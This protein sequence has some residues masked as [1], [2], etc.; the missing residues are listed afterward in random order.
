MGT[1]WTS[2]HYNYEF[3]SFDTAWGYYESKPV[4]EENCLPSKSKRRNKDKFKSPKY[5]PNTQHGSSP[6]QRKLMANKFL[7]FIVEKSTPIH[8][9]Q[10]LLSRSKGMNMNTVM[11]VLYTVLEVG[12]TDLRKFIKTLP[13]LPL[14]QLYEEI[15]GKYSQY[16]LEDSE[17]KVFTSLKNYIQENDK[18]EWSEE[19]SDLELSDILMFFLVMV[20]ANRLDQVCNLPFDKLYHDGQDVLNNLPNAIAFSDGGERMEFKNAKD[21]KA[22]ILYNVFI[23][24][25]PPTKPICV[26]M[27]KKEDDNDIPF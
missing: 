16:R 24:E 20:K 27:K 15:I 3:K 21:L 5:G 26:V 8:I 9:Y 12:I 14:Q 13:D 23:A 25:E 17:L 6:K 18:K 1:D 4:D 19:L 11:S 2:S 7:P 22:F 10:T